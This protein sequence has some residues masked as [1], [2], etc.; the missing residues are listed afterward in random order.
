VNVASTSRELEIA[1]VHR[2]IALGSM[3]DRN[4]R[5]SLESAGLGRAVSE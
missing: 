1:L 4:D 2:S 3:R 5:A